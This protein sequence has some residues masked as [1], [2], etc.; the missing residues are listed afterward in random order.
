LIV[1]IIN[2]RI[3]H[4]PIH[5]LEVDNASKRRDCQLPLSCNSGH[6]DRSDQINQNSRCD[7]VPPRGCRVK[8]NNKQSLYDVER[9]G[10]GLPKESN[11]TK[12][13][14]FLVR[15]MFWVGVNR[16]SPG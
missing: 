7:A 13:G 9:S 8:R 14:S 5:P 1:L 15:R 10:H 2:A 12:L 16:G 3:C 4:Q 6:F 11:T